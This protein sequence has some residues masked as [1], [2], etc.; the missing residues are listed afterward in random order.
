MPPAGVLAAHDC[1]RTRG[2]PDP[3]HDRR[4]ARCGTGNGARVLMCEDLS[5]AQELTARAVVTSI[6]PVTAAVM[7]AWRRSASRSS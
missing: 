1:A 2:L 3:A 5:L 6:C 7:R 4:T